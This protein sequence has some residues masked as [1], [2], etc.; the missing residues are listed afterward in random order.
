MATLS[1]T[2]G[3]EVRTTLSTVDIETVEVVR[4]RWKILISVI[5]FWQA[6]N[7]HRHIVLYYCT[8]IYNVT[9]TSIVLHILQVQIQ[10]IDL[11]LYKLQ[12]CSSCSEYLNMT[13][14]SMYRQLTSGGLPTCHNSVTQSQT[15]LIKQKNINASFYGSKT[16]D[17][18]VP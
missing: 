14:H 13:D 12:S 10:T 5:N 3:V 1:Y 2:D 9:V 7:K 18:T 11:E 17:V 6:S 4:Y 15:S 16:W 8:Y